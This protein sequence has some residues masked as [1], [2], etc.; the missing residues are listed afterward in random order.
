MT[1]AVDKDATTANLNIADLEHLM[2]DLDSPERPLRP[3]SA[4]I[5]FALDR[6]KE[7][8][9][10]HDFLVGGHEAGFGA[11]VK[12]FLYKVCRPLLKIVLVNQQNFN[13]E[14]ARFAEMVSSLEA[15]VSFLEKELAKKEADIGNLH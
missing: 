4:R 9:Q 12:N 6:L 14:M 7:I 15:R 1:K 11:K 5:S 8:H 3:E 10:E 13:D 2:R